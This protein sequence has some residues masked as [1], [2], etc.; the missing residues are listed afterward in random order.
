M[1]RYLEREE[2]SV[3]LDNVSI[4]PDIH[5]IP[6]VPDEVDLDNASSV[7][8]ESDSSEETK[9]TE[10]DRR[11]R[12]LKNKLSKEKRLRKEQQK[13]ALELQ[14]ENEKLREYTLRADSAAT[15]GWEGSI[16]A[17]LE[18]SKRNL[19]TAVEVG[20][21]DSQIQAQEEIARLTS[22]LNEIESYKYSQQN[23]TQR[24][25]TEDKSVQSHAEPEPEMYDPDEDDNVYRADWV[26][27]NPWANPQS[28]DFDQ[29][30]SEEVSLYASQLNKRLQREGRQSLIGSK[31]YFKKLNEYVQENF[32]HVNSDLSNYIK[33]PGFSK[34]S[35]VRS[36]VPSAERGSNL[37]P[38]QKEM[39]RHA[40]LSEEEFKKYYQQVMMEEKRRGS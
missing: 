18:L 37:S 16:K 23:Y 19:R 31:A 4:E 1:E 13:R 17:G 12:H 36:S 3:D 10:E 15:S 21:V 35:G 8:R 14:A 22:R 2:P 26:R 30:M 7:I 25:P 11:L 29:D 38:E 32:K 40:G 6:D 5:H 28:L 27:S 24:Q 34:V 20:D 33:K 9:E 39:A